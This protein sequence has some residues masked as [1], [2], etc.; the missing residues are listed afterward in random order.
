MDPVGCWEEGGTPESLNGRRRF[1]RD[2][3]VSPTCVGLSGDEFLVLRGL[4]N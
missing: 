1:P 2:T 4:E 3:V